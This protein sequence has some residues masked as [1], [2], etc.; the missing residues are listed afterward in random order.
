MLSTGQA[1][2][3]IEYGTSM[4]ELEQEGK[5]IQEGKTGKSVVYRINAS[6]LRFSLR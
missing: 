5:V 4:D 2:Y 6:H 3:Y 1:L